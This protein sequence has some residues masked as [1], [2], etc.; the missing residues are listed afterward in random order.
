MAIDN[1]PRS[2]RWGVVEM[3]AAQHRPH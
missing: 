3:V 1:R 2:L